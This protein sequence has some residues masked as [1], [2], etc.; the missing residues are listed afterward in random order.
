[1]KVI[2]I[3]TIVRDELQYPDGSSS[4]SLGGLLHTINAALAI[5]GK[6]DLIV[7]VS[8][9]GKDLY[10]EIISAFREDPRIQSGGLLPCDQPNNT[11]EL[12]YQNQSERTEKS[13]FPMPTL[14]FKEVE[15]YLQGDLVLVNMISGWDIDLD[16]LVQL[17]G[18]T[19]AMIA[20]DLHSLMLRRDSDG[21]RHS[22]YFAGLEKWIACADIIQMNEREFDI[23]SGGMI[24]PE[25][26]FRDVCIQSQNI[27]NLTKGADGSE[28]YYY[29]E[30]TIHNLP[31]SPPAEITVIDPTGCGDAFLAGFGIAWYRSKNIRQVAR[32]AN[33][34]AA[35]TGTFKGLPDPEKV[36]QMYAEYVKEDG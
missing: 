11:V 36:G 8:R 29:Q 22:R 21:S 3:G 14:Q 27:F 15:P 20:I 12:V 13:L 26:F 5:L 19:R 9:V 17:R 31:A 33:I 18:N 24:N 6:D 32:A 2:V 1:M 4:S 7:P 35:I 25:Q 30:N 28:T 16:F 10:T 23:Q 34:L